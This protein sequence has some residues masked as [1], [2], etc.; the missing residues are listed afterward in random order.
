MPLGRDIHSTKSYIPP[1]LDED[2]L[3]RMRAPPDY[4]LHSNSAMNDSSSD[5][6]NEGKRQSGLPGTFPGS[7]ATSKDAEYF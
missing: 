5:S 3:A 6:E 4:D 1:S 7:S 2:S